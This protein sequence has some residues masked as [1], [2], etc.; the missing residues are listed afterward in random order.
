MCHIDNGFPLQI[1]TGAYSGLPGP[2]GDGRDLQ[3]PAENGRAL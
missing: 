1:T 2:I 3:G